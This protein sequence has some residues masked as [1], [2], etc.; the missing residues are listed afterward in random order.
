MLEADGIISSAVLQCNGNLFVQNSIETVQILHYRTDDEFEEIATPNLL[1]Q[2]H[3]ELVLQV[4]P[5]VTGSVKLSFR[6]QPFW[7]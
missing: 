1:H 7:E 3:C 4:Q 6:C 2:P 5:V